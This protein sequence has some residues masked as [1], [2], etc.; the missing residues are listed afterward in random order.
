[1]TSQNWLAKCNRK[2]ST[3]CK[4]NFLNQTSMVTEKYQTRN[5]DISKSVLDYGTKHAASRHVLVYSNTIHTSHLLQYTSESV[6]YS[7]INFCSWQI[8]KGKSQCK[9]KTYL[10]LHYQ[11]KNLLIGGK[12]V[13]T[14]HGY[15]WYWTCYNSGTSQ[16][17]FLST[18]GVSYKSC[19]L[20]LIHLLE[21]LANMLSRG[22][23]CW[24]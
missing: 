22:W 9:L 10:K 15:R 11:L 21:H 24:H 8:I 23:L 16:M 19:G 5:T 18:L 20:E 3:E 13:I 1:M 7:F 6:L 17:Y 14:Y 2:F 12:Y 4:L